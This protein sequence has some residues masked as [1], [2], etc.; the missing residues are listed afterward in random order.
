MRA[1]L[2]RDRQVAR[3]VA[4]RSLRTWRV[5]GR[6]A[7]V[8]VPLRFLEFGP[9]RT[10]YLW[11]AMTLKTGPACHRVCIDLAPDRGAIEQPL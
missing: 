4:L 8:A 10:S 7:S 11:W 9:H 6:S 3:D 1:T 2:Y 5:G